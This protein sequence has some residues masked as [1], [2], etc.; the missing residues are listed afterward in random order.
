MV[1]GIL[2]DVYVG[3]MCVCPDEA[4]LVSLVLK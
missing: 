2:P 4:A 3:S 1:E